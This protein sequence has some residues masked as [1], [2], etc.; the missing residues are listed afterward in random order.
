MTHRSMQEIHIDSLAFAAGVMPPPNMAVSHARWVARPPKRRVRLLTGWLLI[1]L[2]I[3]CK[4]MA[5]WLE[6]EKLAECT[7]R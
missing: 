6:G 7:A 3:F 2:S 4:K 5:D 1:Q